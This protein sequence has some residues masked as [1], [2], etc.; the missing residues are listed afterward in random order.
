MSVSIAWR[1]V[2]KSAKYTNGM[3]TGHTNNIATAVLRV[4]KYSAIAIERQVGVQVATVLILAVL[5]L[6][7]LDPLAQER[8]EDLHGGA[9]YNKERKTKPK[10]QGAL[11]RPARCGS[12]VLRSAESSMLSCQAPPL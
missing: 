10:R 1:R 11:Q 7:V 9:G 4:A 8:P 6:R 3:P 2:H 5:V 12:E